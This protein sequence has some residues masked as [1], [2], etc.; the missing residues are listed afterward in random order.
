MLR[1]AVKAKRVVDARPLL[2]RFPRGA[3]GQSQPCPTRAP[4]RLAQSLPARVA[5]LPMEDS[6]GS[7]RM[8]FRD[9]LAQ[10]I[11]LL[12]LEGRVSYRALA[13]QFDLDDESLDALRI[14]LVRVKRLAIDED[15]ESLAWAGRPLVLE[16]N[17]AESRAAALPV[18]LLPR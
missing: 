11:G 18:P 9:V 6:R 13:F 5:S 1:C 16:A 10:V 4:D 15:G 17:A 3:G 7:G 2:G 8:R 14:E 12:V